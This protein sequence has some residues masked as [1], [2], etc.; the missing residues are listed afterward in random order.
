MN[1]NT[2][3]LLVTILHFSIKKKMLSRISLLTESWWM[4]LYRIVTHMY[5][6][7]WV[8]CKQKAC[9]PCQHFLKTLWIWPRWRAAPAS[10]ACAGPSSWQPSAGRPFCWWRCTRCRSTPP[11]SS[12]SSPGTSGDHR[13]SPPF[14]TLRGTVGSRAYDRSTHKFEFCNIIIIHMYHTHKHSLAL[15]R[16]HK[17]KFKIHK[18]S[19]VSTML[20]YT[21]VQSACN[22]HLT[23]SRVLIKTFASSAV[24]HDNCDIQS[25]QV[26][27]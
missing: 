5:T 10:A 27:C 1:S 14:A 12:W 17:N 25:M 19:S 22:L 18:N 20:L 26:R 3:L 7:T 6:N 13:A 15:T 2:K 23:K 11:R 21:N 8:Y 16:K 9:H 24:R 4:F